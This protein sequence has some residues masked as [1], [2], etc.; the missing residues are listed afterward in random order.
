MLTKKKRGFVIWK[1]DIPDDFKAINSDFSDRLPNVIIEDN[2]TA[3]GKA[4]G[5]NVQE[6]Y[7]NSSKI[8]FK[9]NPFPIKS[10]IY[11]HK[12]CIN[13]IKMIIEKV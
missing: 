10:S 8:K 7:N 1:K 3:S 4:R 12:N 6:A 9:S 13:S 2:K 5:T 11:F